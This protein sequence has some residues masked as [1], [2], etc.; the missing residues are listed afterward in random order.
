MILALQLRWCAHGR[1]VKRTTAS[2]IHSF[3]TITHSLTHALTHS[4]SLTHSLT[5]THW[6]ISKISPVH[7]HSRGQALAPQPC[8]LVEKRSVVGKH[9]E[10]E[11]SVEHR[12]LP[13]AVAAAAVH[14]QRHRCA[15]KHGRQRGLWS[16]RVGRGRVVAVGVVVVA[17]AVDVVIDII[18]E[19]D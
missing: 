4:L 14:D 13:V 12:Q 9:C 7:S 19:I 1:E 3:T 11:E 2:V 18:S 8:G 17:A 10:A 16:R 5:L 15:V 6:S